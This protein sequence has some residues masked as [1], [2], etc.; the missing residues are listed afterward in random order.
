[1][2]SGLVVDYGMAVVVAANIIVVV[3]VVAIVTFAGGGNSAANTMAPIRRIFSDTTIEAPRW[4]L[5]R[6]CADSA[7]EIC[8]RVP[9][10]A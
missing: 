9:V 4:D 3:V 2:I 8:C 5:T 7:S 10:G 1:M 6:S